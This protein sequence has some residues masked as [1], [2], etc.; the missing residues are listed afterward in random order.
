M[1]DQPQFKP[2]DH[3]TSA[4]GYVGIV[5]CLVRGRRGWLVRVRWTQG[6]HESRV[7]PQSLT[8]SP[9]CADRAS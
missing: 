7:R 1:T 3:V 6:G 2:S 8:L 4:Q 9:L 5:Q